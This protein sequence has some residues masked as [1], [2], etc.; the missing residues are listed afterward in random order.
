M[1]PPSNFTFVLTGY[2]DD[3][4]GWKQIKIFFRWLPGR[5]GSVTP[6]QL[7]FFSLLADMSTCHSREVEGVFYSISVK[8]DPAFMHA[9]LLP[10]RTAILN[11][12]E[13]AVVL[14]IPPALFLLW[15]VKMSAVINFHMRAMELK[16]LMKCIIY[17][18]ESCPVTCLSVW[19]VLW[20]QVKTQN[21]Q[22]T[23]ALALRWTTFW[24]S[25]LSR[26]LHKLATNLF[27]S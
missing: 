16:Q 11:G 7:F 6:C 17:S 1:K 25:T 20:P 23:N 19:F 3:R 22:W 24:V 13:S 21:R 18:R 5:Y 27:W 26:C 15:Q 8:E 9:G 14:L 12:T 10:C 4:S 2:Y